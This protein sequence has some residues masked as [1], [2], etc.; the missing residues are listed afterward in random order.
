M[1]LVAGCTAPATYMIFTTEAFVVRQVSSSF[2]MGCSLQNLVE[3]LAETFLPLNVG[4]FIY[5]I[6]CT[7]LGRFCLFLRRI[8]CLHWR[9]LLRRTWSRI[10]RY[11][12]TTFPVCRIELMTLV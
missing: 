3:V 5:E 10:F 4:N 1:A 8:G 11:V 2:E 9:M 12:R 6:I 7:L